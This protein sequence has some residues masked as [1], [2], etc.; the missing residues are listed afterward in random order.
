MIDKNNFFI[1]IGIIF[2]II[3]FSILI[4]IFNSGGSSSSSSFGSF[5]KN[6]NTA[7]MPSTLKWGNDFNHKYKKLE[8]E[9]PKKSAF[10]F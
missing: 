5:G 4:L 9:R 7:N 10:K 8:K 3:L 6:R 2:S 1:I